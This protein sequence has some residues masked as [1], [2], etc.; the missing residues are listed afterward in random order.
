MRLDI[1][2]ILLCLSSPGSAQL[3]G[4]YIFRHLDQSDGLLHTA[5][6]GIGQDAHGYIWILTWNGLQR[7][8]GSRFVNY[9]EIINNSSFGVFH[10]SELF[11]DTL[12]Q[13]VW[14]TKG[15][16]SEKLDIATNRLTTLDIEKVLKDDTLHKTIVGTDEDQNQYL[17]GTWGVIRYEQQTQNKSNSLFSINPGQPNRNSYVI[18]DPA[19]GDFWF[20]NF[21]YF[22]IADSK[23]GMIQSSSRLH[24]QHPLL[25][26]L[27]DRYGQT[28][29]IRY[30]MLDSYNNIWISTWTHLLHRYNLQTKQLH[31]YSLKNILNMQNGHEDRDNTLLVNAMYEDRQKNLWFATDYA[32]L[33]LYQREKDDFDF[34]TSDDKINSGLKYNFTI[35][36]IFQDRDDNLWLGTDRGISIFNPYRNHFQTIRH[37]DGND[38]SLPKF[39]INDVIETSQGEILVAT[40]GGGITIFDQQW[41]FLRNVH[42]PGPAVLDLVW[43]FVRLDD[44]TI[45][46]GTQQGYIHQYDPINRTF[47]TVHPK[48]I[49]NSTISTMIKDRNGNILIG[50]FN[51]KIAYWNKD[52]NKF[53]PY[54]D[55]GSKQIKSNKGI[56]SMYVDKN[57][58]YWT[59]TASGL[60]QYDILNREFTHIYPSESLG[61]GVEVTFQGIAELNDSTLLLTGIY[62]GLYSFAIN[63]KIFSR[64]TIDDFNSTTSTFAIRKDHAAHFWITTNFSIVRFDSALTQQTIFSIDH[65][66]MNAAFGSS[67]FLELENGRWVITTTAELI[68][69]DPEQIGRDYNDQPKVEICGFSVFN[70]VMYIDSFLLADKPVILSHDK[71][72]ISIEFSALTFT[73]LRQP[74]YYY[75]L[76][77]VNKDWIHTTTKQF[78]DYTDLHPGEYLFEVKAD[79]GD[80]PS[81][82]TSFAIVITPPWWGTWWFRIMC[83]LALGTVM[84]LVLR[85]RIY[86]IRKEAALKHRI[87]ET[88]MM[89]LRSQM[90]PHFIF[91]C[92]NSIDAMIQSNDKYKATV[93]LNKFAKL[94]RNVL[95]SSKQNK[96]PLSKDMET[97]Q[98]Y[99]DLELF[100]HQDK[101]TA[102]VIAE[103]ELL[104]NDY[105]VPPLIV[106]PYVENAI[107]HGLRHRT[108]HQGK[109]SV[110]VTRKEEQIVYVIE[111]NGVGRK[112]INGDSKKQS[113]G[114]GM[115]I[116]SD[117][118]RLF[119]DEEIASVHITDLEANGQPAGTR[120]E[121]QLKI[122]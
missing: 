9:P 91:N 47:S 21:S 121:V 109:L 50:L 46:A 17:L 31:T 117:R 7:Y 114:Y 10:D 12:Q 16:I 51:G 83:I 65:S 92:I 60:L 55:A 30:I 28:N 85:N 1:L 57:D 80:G 95:D 62:G 87:A 68:C 41:N 63:R 119:N 88:E 74:N 3:N 4:K 6:R 110:T 116:S 111:D 37:M 70:D 105:K 86:T 13:Q 104:Q 14:V 75:R 54:N 43:S 61:L 26:Q 71:N 29:K 81:P 15:N 32:G 96:I 11:V 94:I 33:L 77:N 97:L 36:S 67:R 18:Q 112:A 101:F 90:N 25:Q 5:V 56:I 84:Y 22:M 48:E 69:F 34:I 107:L 38:A 52:Q 45:W 19:S 93:Y 58:R 98:L 53:Y 27:W 76:K 42:F 39:D 78:A 20:H 108:D 115:Q 66:L 35:Y 99:I 73:D 82:V 23:T 100:R 72:F 89:A 24:H 120:V 40:W 118:V 49:N 106:Q 2:V 102:T 44:G 59:T 79:Y 122:Q 8:D 113:S 103:E 64:P